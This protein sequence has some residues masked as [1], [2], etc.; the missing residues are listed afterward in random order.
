VARTEWLS[1]GIEK[2][3]YELLDHKGNEPHCDVAIVGS[4]YGGAVAAARLAGAWEENHGRQAKVWV[5]ERGREFVPGSFPERFADL[6]GQARIGA[7]EK[8]ETRGQREGLFDVRIG[9]HVS[10]LLANGLGGGSLINAG[11]LARPSDSLLQRAEWQPFAG[12]VLGPY[13]DKAEA[14]LGAAKLPGRAPRKLASLQQLAAGIDGAR[15]ERAAIAVTF[16]KGP[17]AGGV[18]QEACIHCGDCFTGCNHWAKNTLPMNYLPLAWRRGARL[19]TGVTVLSLRRD[20]DGWQL[21]IQFTDRELGKRFGIELP[22]LRARRVILAAGAYGS[23]AILLRSAAEGFKELSSDQLGRRFS[24]NGD[25]IAAGYR[26]AAPVEASAGEA[27]APADRNIGPT[28]TGMIDLRSRFV[29]FV[30]E[31]LTVPAA[32]R[33]AFEEV[34]TTFGGLYSL[35]RIDWSDHARSPGPDPAAIDQAAMARTAV[36]ATIGDD[37]AGGTIKLRPE[38]QDSDDGVYVEWQDVAKAPVF[39]EAMKLLEEAH[40]DGAMLIPN[41]MWRLLPAT[42]GQMLEGGEY[43]GAVLTVHPLGGCAMARRAEDGVVNHLGQVFSAQQGDQVHSTLAVLDGAIMPT[44][45]GTNPC[46][47]IAAVSEYAVERLAREWRVHTADP[48]PGRVPL[49]QPPERPMHPPA[50]WA[51]PRPTAIRL[52]ERLTGEIVLERDKFE[53]ELELEYREVPDLEALVSGPSKVLW[54]DKAR[55]Q[56]RRERSEGEEEITLRLAGKLDVLERE[57]TTV[58]DRVWSAGWAWWA[59]RGKRET[60]AFVK[61]IPRRLAKWLKNLPG[62]LWGYLTGREATEPHTPGIWQRLKQWVAL[63]SHAGERRL[64][65][66]VFEVLDGGID[67]LHPGDRLVGTKR[68]EY[69]A[70]AGRD[71]PWPSPWEQLT[72]LP[73]A[74]R[75]NGQDTALG[76][77]EVD[78]P[79]FVQHHAT[80]LQI[81]SQENQPRAIADF[82]SLF[83]YIARVLGKIH[84]WSLRAPDYPNPYPL[85]AFDPKTY[86]LIKERALKLVGDVED[87]RAHRL[88]GDID[89]FERTVFT[90]EARKLPQSGLLTHY[91]LKAPRRM[92]R[93]PVLLI[94]GL[95]AGGNTFTLPTVQENLVQHLAQRGFDPWVLDLS[96][97][98]GLPTSKGPVEWTFEDIADVD[99]PRAIAKVREQTG[100]PQVSIVAHCI[101]AAM[102]S[103]AALSGRVKPEWVRAAVLSQ[104]GPLLE[105]RPT[106]RFRGYVASHL[107]Y[108]LDI[109]EFDNVSTLS[110]FSRF[111]DRLLVG[112][113]PYP[114]YEWGAHHSDD[115]PVTHEQYC[116][117]SYGI[118]GR[119]FEHA[120]LNEE[121]LERLGDYLGH[122][123][124]KTYQQTIF[125]ATM[126][127]LTDKSG[128]NL[129]TYENIERN[130]RFPICFLHGEENQ[131]F[132][133]STSER[134]FDLVSSVFWSR[135]LQEL[136]QQNPKLRYDHS[137]YSRGK[138]LRLV[139]IDDYGHQDCLIGQRAH[140]DVYP[141]ISGFLRQA[142]NAKVEASP[143]LV[144]VRPP[145]MGPIVGWVRESRDGKGL[146]ARLLFVPNESRSK[147][148]WAMTVV[149]KDGVPVRGYARFRKLMTDPSQP[150]QALDVALPED[151]GEYGDYAVVLVT[152]HKEQF[153]PEPSQEAGRPRFDD[154]FGEDLDRIPSPPIPELPSEEG[155]GDSLVESVLA[156]C[157]DLRSVG[158]GYR[159]IP[160]GERVSNKYYARPVSTA[161]LP[162][163]VLASA[164]EVERPGSVCFSLASCRYAATIADREVADAAFGRLR[165]LL[166]P[167]SPSRPQLLFLAGDSIYA[168]ATYGIF[169]PEAPKDRF[170]ERYLEAWTAPNARE[171]L[172]SVPTYPMLDD[173]EVKDGFE[174]R[175]P[176]HKAGLE[177]FQAFELR[178][179]PAFRDPSQANLGAGPYWYTAKAGGY[180]FF[181]ADTRTDRRRVHGRPSAEALIMG[182]EQM[183]PLKEWLSRLH[184]RDAEMPKFIVSP[185][186]VAPW[187]RETRGSLGYALRADAW[188]GFPRSLHDLFMFIAKEGIRNVVFLSGDY[189]CSL[190]C[191]M[192]LS[193]NGGKP[194]K[195]YSIVSSGMYSPYPFANTR[196][197]DLELAFDGPYAHWAGEKDDGLRVSYDARVIA[198]CGSFASVGAQRE[199]NRYSISVTFD[200]PHG[201]PPIQVSL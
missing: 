64:M 183:G 45:I 195:A 159:P 94:H 61:S 67:S 144:V 166:E 188:D 145:L 96:T 130:L 56:L 153:E 69:I 106:N 176:E 99:I 54:V 78:L 129:V 39:V 167:R 58:F 185:S 3:A 37:G 177:A 29:P 122:I 137:L 133:K 71:G 87:R 46:L 191:H 150:T 127:R 30:I 80:Q 70:D 157:K 152:L 15:S 21:E 81:A 1:E 100:D 162:R 92:Q 38:T 35:E 154:P 44:A 85:Y 48:E 8:S 65:Q 5:L 104:V 138:S 95:G 199:N 171:V 141:H 23:T 193:N 168:D 143:S 139:M 91:A 20:G 190:F 75:R 126:R 136:W 116:V 25:M 66:Y 192:A 131:V 121:T 26:M 125:Y 74:R 181:V 198:T 113:L 132:D 156:C 110:A 163:E 187:S 164:R 98:I 17:S 173:H 170:D 135:D 60:R 62:K 148:D 149:L 52:A 179:T 19:V 36:Y 14:M 33:R 53:A 34:V 196:L 77:L 93:G 120:N 111:L 101:G 73:L 117:R 41:P 4:G 63:A 51:A 201:P 155:E 16:A 72:K 105:L 13:F 9:E 142:K 42:M 114:W 194:V 68:I 89:G 57:P 27:D 160:T 200:A 107:K 28:I 189:H 174:G 175:G 172:R 109:D 184:H 88:P 123:R 24:T 83:A 50:E 82:F 169:D 140:E 12:D 43:G 108:Y 10:A 90:L 146:V 128:A 119:L 97:S 40:R 47:T 118:Y 76:V 112:V 84:I 11:V 151:E 49:R 31:E 6:L 182:K 79:Y 158:R 186:V 165:R 18:A 59:N 161:I 124:F 178:L 115:E 2:L 134:S 102:F 7:R 55:L 86:D 180:E 103:M 22:R 147:P 197:D 32:L